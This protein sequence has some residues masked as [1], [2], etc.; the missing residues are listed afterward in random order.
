MQK[1]Y[2]DWAECQTKIVRPE[3]PKDLSLATIMEQEGYHRL[4]FFEHLRGRF[5]DDEPLLAETKLYTM[6]YLIRDQ[7]TPTQ[8]MK[9]EEL[10]AICGSLE[11]G[12]QAGAASSSGK[13]AAESDFEKEGESEKKAKVAEDRKSVV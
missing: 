11:S 1:V 10:R 2:E 13:R 7:L 4:L 12:P 3:R 6:K 5:L 8:K 9:V